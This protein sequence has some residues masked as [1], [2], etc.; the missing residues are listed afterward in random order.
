MNRLYFYTLLFICLSALNG[1]GVVVV[2]AINTARGGENDLYIVDSVKDLSSFSSLTLNQFTGGAN[3]RLTPELLTY[4]NS[5]IHEN[6]SENGV[7]LSKDGQLHISGTVI[8]LVDTFSSKR[9]LVEVRLENST[10]GSFLGSV[11]VLG[12]AMGLRGIE[13][14]ADEIADGITELLKTHHYPNI[15]N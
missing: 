10:T 9:I 6:L 7:D 3:E 5:E 13:T 11:N 2:S 4:M 12:E 15:E 8:Y 1:C 14:A